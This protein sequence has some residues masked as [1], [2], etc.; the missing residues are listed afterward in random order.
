MK[1]VSKNKDKSKDWKVPPQ[2]AKVGKYLLLLA[3]LAVTIGQITGAIKG[4]NPSGRTSKESARKPLPPEVAARL[5]AK[6]AGLP[7]YY[8]LQT[9]GVEPDGMVPQPTKLLENGYVS[10]VMHGKGHYGVPSRS[11]GVEKAYCYKR[12]TYSWSP[13]TGTGSCVAQFFRIGYAFELPLV[14]IGVGSEIVKTEPA[15]TRSHDITVR[16]I[17][18]SGDLAVIGTFQPGCEYLNYTGKFKALEGIP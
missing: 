18:G 16:S 8:S 14:D 1:I 5:R 6:V 7:K 2:V 10:F 9:N 3:V 11:G 17:P 4:E 13:K 15:F 12:E